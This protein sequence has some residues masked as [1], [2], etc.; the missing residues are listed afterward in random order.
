MCQ[1]SKPRDHA[2]EAAINIL[3]NYARGYV[4]PE[5]SNPSNPQWRIDNNIAKS[6]AIITRTIEQATAD[7]RTT[8]RDSIHHASLFKQG[9]DEAEQRA[10][11][12]T[13][14]FRH[15]SDDG[16]SAEAENKRL[17]EALENYATCCDGCTCGDG[18][19]HD[20][21]RAALARPEGTPESEQKGQP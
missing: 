3:S 2:R 20:V 17:R 8:L 5:D 13:E 9:M 16:I 19:D 15:A 10:E 18:W 1:P 11:A 21:A 4:H 6:A 14:A 12:Q 7:L